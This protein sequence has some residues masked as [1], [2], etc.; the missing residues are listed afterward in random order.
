[1]GGINQLFKNL[2]KES[3]RKTV[4]LIHGKVLVEWFSHIFSLNDAPW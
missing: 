4:L 1:M 3:Y 2:I